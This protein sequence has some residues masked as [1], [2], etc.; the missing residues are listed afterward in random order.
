M[1]QPKWID[2]HIHVSDRGADGSRREHLLPDLLR[3]LDAEDADLRFVLNSDGYWYQICRDEPDGCHRAN[4]FIHRL[5]EGARERLYGSCMVNPNFVDESLRTMEVCFERWGF[6]QLGEMLQYML[7]Y[8]MNSDTTASI[9]RR[10]VDY[11]VPIQVHIS[12]SNRAQGGFSGGR[13]ELEDL[14]GLVDRVPDAKYIL[15]HA[16]G[17]DQDDPPVIDEYVDLIE[18]QYGSWPRNFWAEIRDF[19]SPGLPSALRR[20]PVDRLIT[21]TDWTTRV[22]PPFMPYGMIFA[23]ESPDENPYPPCIA[24]MVGFMKRAGATDEEVERIGFE[25]AASLLKLEMG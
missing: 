19:S 17:S 24:S 9:A 18:R 21:G 3:V 14:F 25:N 8:R 15:A 6:V 10:A 7:H 13:E 22:G 11:D 5:V 16:V 4:A 23:L 2:T 1:A 20:I 12:T